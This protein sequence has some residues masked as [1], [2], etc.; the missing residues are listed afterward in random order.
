[1]NTRTIPTSRLFRSN[2]I[3]RGARRVDRLACRGLLA[4]VVVLIAAAGL[5]VPAFGSEQPIDFFGADGTL[6]G[7]FSDARGVAVNQTTGDVYVSDAADRVER[8]QR[9]PDNTYSFVSAWGAGVD[10]SQSGSGFQVC[11]VAANCQAGTASA[12]GG[13]VSFPQRSVPGV[14]VDQVTG[15]V[16]VADPGNLR[17]NVY[18]ADGSFVQSMGFGV[19]ATTGGS[20]YEVCPATD[21]CRAGVAGSAAGQLAT[22]PEP[23][24]GFAIAVSPPGVPGTRALYV[25]DPGNQ[26]ID[27]WPLDGSAPS[28]I[29]SAATFVPKRPYTVAVDPRGIVYAGND[30]AG[31]SAIDRYDTTGVDGA[32]IGFLAPISTGSNDEQQLTV[33][34]T[35]GTYTLTFTPPGGGAPETTSELAFDAST[36]SVEQALAALPGIGVANVQVTGGPGDASGSQPYTIL[37]HRALGALVISPLTVAD[38]SSPLSGGSG[39]SVSNSQGQP[40]AIPTGGNAD[41]GLAVD[42][43]TGVLYAVRGDDGP[44][45]QWGPGDP[46]GLLAPPTADDGRLGTVALYNA[47]GFANSFYYNVTGVAVDPSDGRLYLPSRLAFDQGTGQISP[48]GGSPGVT[49]LGAEGPP[50]TA[51]LDSCDPPGATQVTCHATINPNG[52]PDTSYHFEYSTDGTNWSVEPSVALGQQ[53]TAQSVSGTIDAAPAGLEPNTLYHLR[54]VAQR[55]LAPS[56][57]SN[58]VTVTTAP[59]AP[60]ALTTGAPDRA[61]DPTQRGDDV[62]LRVRHHDRLRECHPGPF[63]RVGRAHGAGRGE[64]LRARA[65]DDLSLP[66]GRR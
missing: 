33:S 6:G 45:Q 55:N 62:S 60:I 8:F 29:G 35:A 19:D 28:S 25:A 50:P 13:A 64:R 23:G 22:P 11:T 38:G 9:N 16:Y 30:D 10:A 18:S 52:P 14:A 27:V 21:S 34:A 17:V 58:E 49:V 1:M 12:T 7:Q 31:F 32:G 15:D 59:A 63:G 54:V 24:L 44:V 20:G 2:P 3:S 51:S 39:A 4:L 41:L 40:G 36:L 57:V 37:F 47:N 53:T 48:N 26:R 42:P 56:V 66:A 46:P 5:A 43:G 61:G 65:G